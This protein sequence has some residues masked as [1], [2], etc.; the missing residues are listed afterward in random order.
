MLKSKMNILWLTEDFVGI[1]KFLT[2]KSCKDEG[3]PAQYKPLIHFSNKGHTIDIVSLGNKIVFRLPISYNIRS[4]I[5]KKPTINIITKLGWGD[6]RVIFFI[7]I[8]LSLVVSIKFIRK[9][10]Y[11][12]IYSNWEFQSVVGAILSY[13]YKIPNV[14]RLY[15]S[16]LYG[17]IGSKLIFK[18]KILHFNRLLP[19]IV[20]KELLIITED[21]TQANKIVDILNINK[22][23]IISRVN[24]VDFNPK[25]IDF[26]YKYKFL[27][28][29]FIISYIGSVG[30]WKRT[31]I[32]LK[33]LNDVIKII[34]N[35]NY[36]IIGDGD[37][38]KKMKG[39]ILKLGLE[40][41]VTFTGRVTQQE[42]IYLQTRSDIY[43]SLYNYTN[44]TNTFLE[45]I[46][47]GIPSLVIPNGGTKMVAK[48]KENCLF[49]DESNIVES[50][51]KNIEYLYNHKAFRKKL[52]IKAK[53]YAH[54]HLLSWDERCAKDLIA[55]EKV[56]KRNKL[57]R[58]K[59]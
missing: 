43:V 39:D 8:I 11:D 33:S 52:G 57:I 18:E 21:G 28:N 35:V 3:M 20:K 10:N 46:A 7:N 9:N 26:G 34:P 29:K 19:F 32:F 5:I 48:N 54:K 55:I 31:D 45:S 38:L 59:V 27:K 14:V 12:V 36:L 1:R 13:L 24:G 30:G 47:G 37:Q 58:G 42:R 4:T 22:R 49:I 16:N 17:R 25:V 50:L 40:K 53:I 51:I 44:L 23:H 56:V 2:G 6:V 15:G 41:Y